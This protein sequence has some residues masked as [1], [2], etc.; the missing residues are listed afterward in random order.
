VS[1]D[2]VIS[3]T[4][5]LLLTLLFASA[6]W[7][8]LSGLGAFRIV[9]H[10]YEVLPPVLV[11]P[12]TAAVVTAEVGVAAAFPWPASA[13]AA[14]RVAM[15][16]LAAYGVAIAVNLARGRRTLECGCAPSAY[17]QPLSEW[18]LARN[19]G[20]IGVCAIALLPEATRP[21]G[22]VDWMTV[23]GAVA[24][25][26]MTWAAAVRLLALASP[27]PTVRRVAR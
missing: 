19:V 7:H 1:V 9:L 18:L 14:A 4:L 25:G 10:D 21:W 12:A 2:P 6:A 3:V 20:L 15:V 8:K 13:P 22:G 16:L 5:R 24:T 17:R 23:V 26:A 27:A 11:A